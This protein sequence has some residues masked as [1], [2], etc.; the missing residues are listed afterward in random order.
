MTFTPARE[1]AAKRPARTGAKPSLVT[2]G[3]ICPISGAHS[4]PAGGQAAAHSLVELALPDS[5]RLVSLHRTGG[6]LIVWADADRGPPHVYVL[7]HM[8]RRVA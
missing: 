7:H 1:I 4:C 5:G 3:A 8:G 2:V 6:A